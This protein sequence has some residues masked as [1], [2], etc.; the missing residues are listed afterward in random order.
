M[1][2]LHVPLVSIQLKRSNTWIL[3]VTILILFVFSSA[4]DPKRKTLRKELEEQQGLL[5]HCIEKL[6]LV[7]ENRVALVSQLKEALHEQVCC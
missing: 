4:K 7:E 3:E 6:K 2:I 1:L 5:K